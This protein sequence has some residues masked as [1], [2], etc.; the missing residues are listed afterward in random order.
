[1]ISEGFFSN[2]QTPLKEAFST[3]T[4]GSYLEQTNKIGKLDTKYED[5]S[6]NIVVYD[7]L[8]DSVESDEKYADF[9]GN[10][11]HYT[12]HPST[13]KDAVKED[14]HM[15]ILQQNNSYIIGMI[16]VIT[17]MITTYLV[18]KK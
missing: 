13:V 7:A 3:T 12:D 17:V 16:T 15:M 14:I 9:S 1:M 18:T 8:K 2:P 4:Y 5:I 10:F 6:Q 11:L